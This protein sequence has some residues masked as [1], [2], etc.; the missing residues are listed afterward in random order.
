MHM[1]E[2]WLWNTN[3]HIVSL[4]H[5]SIQTL[6]HELYS[7]C[8]SAIQPSSGV[9][10]IEKRSVNLSKHT[11][12]HTRFLLVVERDMQWRHHYCFKNCKTIR[13]A[14]AYILRDDSISSC[15]F[16]ACLI[17]VMVHSDQVPTS[18]TLR[19]PSTL[20]GQA[21]SVGDLRIIDQLRQEANGFAAP[22]ISY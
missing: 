14:R 8:H 20:N 9:Y 5:H 22:Y 15:S 17:Y 21:V 19:Q 11:N 6:K 7:R 2:N 16:L 13:L 4:L 10:K 1:K 18:R 3:P 12:W